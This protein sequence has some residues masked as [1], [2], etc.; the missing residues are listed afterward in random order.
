LYVD[1]QK[2]AGAPLAELIPKEP[3]DGLQVGVDARSPVTA[4]PKGFVGLIESVELFSGA[5]APKN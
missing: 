3:N 1:G 4:E 5:L 2:V